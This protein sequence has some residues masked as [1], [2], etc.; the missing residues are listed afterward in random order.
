MAISPIS[1]V[2]VQPALPPVPGNAKL[3]PIDQVSVRAVL[4]LILALRV[5]PSAPR[6][7]I[8]SILQAGLA[9]TLADLPFLNADVVLESDE[10]D[11][12]QLE[13]GSDDDVGVWF[14]VRDVPELDFDDLERRWFPST[15]LPIPLLVPLPFLHSER[16]PVLTVQANFI[17]NGLLLALNMHHSVMDGAGMASVISRWA[18]HV[19]ALYEGRMVQPDDVFPEEAMDRSVMFGEY[20]DLKV[21][22]FPCYRARKA[23]RKDVVDVKLL[24]KVMFGD[25]AVKA[26]QSKLELIYWRIN[27]EK[28][29]A[30]QDSAAPPTLALPKL[31]ENSILSALIWRQLTRAR[32]LRD[33]NMY[34]TNFLFTVDTRLRI[35]P[36]LPAGYVGNAILYAKA[37]ASVEEIESE[38]PGMLY[39]LAKRITDATDWWTAERIW[40]LFGAID[41]CPDL[42]GVE[43]DGDIHLGS[44]LDFSS[45]AGMRHSQLDFGPGLGEVKALRL[46]NAP[47]RDGHSSIT[48]RHRDGALEIVMMMERDVITRLKQD[49]EWT[50]F[51][52]VAWTDKAQLH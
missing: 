12:L 2:L 24:E 36:P 9:L 39:E 48:P 7:K 10:Q 30:L 34:S 42:R 13:T 19:A 26:E 28:L 44:A 3:S 14:H 49:P 33:R 15:E 43:L 20:N 5:S 23:I 27:A 29:A 47:V 16:T 32:R 6:S 52:E 21:T 38:A 37:T 35:E 50:A 51:A 22:D 17:R 40:E 41:A 4:P 25:M 31:T 45:V 46:P 18:K 1:S 8:V 11:T